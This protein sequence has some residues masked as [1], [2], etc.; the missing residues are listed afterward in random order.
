MHPRQ[1][2]RVIRLEGQTAR[3]QLKQQHADAIDIA[4]RGWHSAGCLLRRI[5]VRRPP[6][7]L[8]RLT[9]PWLTGVGPRDAEV[10]HLGA[11][12]GGDQDILRFQITMH[13]AALMGVAHPFAHLARD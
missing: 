4:G 12:I 13:Q 6:N 2:C 7:S 9:I 3:Q 8:G 1:L 11:P 5:V 10:G